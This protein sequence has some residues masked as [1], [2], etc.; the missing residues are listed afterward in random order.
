MG[1]LSTFGTKLE[2][3][4]KGLASFS[5]SVS[6]ETFNADSVKIATDAAN[7]LADLSKVVADNTAGWEWITGEDGLD[8]FGEKIAT[9]G[10]KLKAFCT[11]VSGSEFDYGAVTTAINQVARFVGMARTIG[12]DG[13]GDLY[14]LAT[15]I[16][17]IGGSL[18]GFYTET[19][20]I[21][22]NH[23]KAMATGLEALASVNVSDTTTLQS[24]INSLGEVSTDGIDKFVKSFNES[25][26]EVT[27]AVASML[28]TAKEAISTNGK[29]VPEAFGEITTNSLKALSNI[30]MYLKFAV[31]GGNLVQG[32]AAGITANTFL[33]VARAKAMA[34]AALAA[35]KAVLAIN[36]PSKA[37]MK[38]GE[39]VPEGFSM[40]IDKL[41]KLVVG[42]S[43]SMAEDA[44]DG[45]KNA[46]ARLVDVVNSDI[47]SQPTIR[48]ILD[49]SEIESGVGGINSMF[50]MRPSIGLMSNIGSINSM[51]KNHQNGGN[52]DVISAINELGRKIGNTSNTTY[53]VNGVT[54]DDGSNISNAVKSLVRAAKVERRI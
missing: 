34:L 53:N 23:F 44:V 11:A 38:V 27:A 15:N 39:S 26:D 1:D 14:E 20:S 10:D 50:G 30:W 18:S 6:S 46:I 31:A 9:L 51:M 13:I 32:F 36:S 28:E 3:F 12:G 45:T 35:A 19:S 33:A 24:F 54:Y 49:L 7:G 5:K 17:D 47:D 2:G 48:P 4:G 21:D 25:S 16:E 8:T 42:S 29:V 41:S 52:S 43:E 37:F 40:G 22:A